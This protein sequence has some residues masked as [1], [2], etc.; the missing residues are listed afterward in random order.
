MC[1]IEE[2]IKYILHKCNLQF[3]SFQE[4]D[5]QIIPRILL[6]DDGV[7]Q[8]IKEDIKDLKSIFSSSAMTSLQK[9]ASNKQKWPLLNLVRQILKNLNFKLE[10]FRKSNGYNKNGKKIFIRYY[11]IVKLKSISDDISYNNT[12]KNNTE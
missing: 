4:L 3:K 8:T 1:D 10:P 11:R 5:G 6:L 9:N 12:I 7:Y 2:K